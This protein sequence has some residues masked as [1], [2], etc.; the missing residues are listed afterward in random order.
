MGDSIKAWEERQDRGY[1]NTEEL[2]T[3]VL[4][5]IDNFELLS[6]EEKVQFWSYYRKKGIL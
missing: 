1:K 6:L 3:N 5:M 2:F 4:D